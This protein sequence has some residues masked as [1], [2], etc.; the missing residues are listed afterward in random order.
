MYLLIIVLCKWPQGY[1][2]VIVMVPWGIVVPET[3]KCKSM[4]VFAAKEKK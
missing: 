2:Q 4:C 3:Y 1:N